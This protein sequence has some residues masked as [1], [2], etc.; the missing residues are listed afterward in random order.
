MTVKVLPSPRSP[1]PAAR[2]VAATRRTSSTTAAPGDRD[3]YHPRPA[4]RAER[5]HR[6]QELRGTVIKDTLYPG[7]T[8]PGTFDGKFIAL[9][10]ALTV[11]AIWY[12]ASLF[13]RT[14]GPFRRRMR[15]CWPSARRPRA[16]ASICWA[17]AKGDLL[18][19][20]GHRSADQGGWRRSAAGAGESQARLLVAPSSS[21]RVQRVEEDH[22]C[23]LCQAGRVG[24]QF[25]A[26]Q[27]QW[28]NAEVHPL[29][30]GRLDREE[31]KDQTKSGFKMTGAPEPVGLE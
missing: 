1:R 2:F 3:Q 6:G 19:D 21:G 16:R 12:S 28:S 26:S 5:R 8:E 23:R 7:V 24:D 14:A 30:V 29:T 17:G 13:E 27:A 4:G 10:Y 9:N 22:R 11:Y 15:R 20:D 25:V 31:M 18:P